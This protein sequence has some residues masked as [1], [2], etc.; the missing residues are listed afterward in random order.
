MPLLD[1]AIEL[2]CNSDIRED[3]R[4]RLATSYVAEWAAGELHLSPEDDADLVNNIASLIVLAMRVQRERT[5]EEFANVGVNSVENA[6][7][8]L[9]ERDAEI[10][11]L[12]R[13][14][15]QR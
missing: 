5:E 7:R 9:A 8:L 12:E 4:E 1:E 3:R 11:R 6:E 10:T 2:L 14:L 13:K 15:A